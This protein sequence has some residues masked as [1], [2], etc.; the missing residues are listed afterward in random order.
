MPRD[1]SDDEPDLITSWFAGRS[2]YGVL[3]DRAED[4]QGSER[5]EKRPGRP[6]DCWATGSPWRNRRSVASEDLPDYEAECED[7]PDRERL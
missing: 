6:P 1:P 5:D 7:P 2:F 4:Q 3:D